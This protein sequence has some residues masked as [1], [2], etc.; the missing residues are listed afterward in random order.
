MTEVRYLGLNLSRVPSGREKQQAGPVGRL[1]DLNEHLL[2]DINLS[3]A[4]RA[5]LKHLD[6]DH[7]WLDFRQPV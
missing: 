7:R 5:C 3:P 6:S 2:C 1:T 4:M